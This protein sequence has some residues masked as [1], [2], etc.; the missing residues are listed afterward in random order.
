MIL[1]A[2]ETAARWGLYGDRLNGGDLVR[3]QDLRVR[4]Q[5]FDLVEV[6]AKRVEN[7]G[8]GREKRVGPAG[9]RHGN[10]PSDRQLAAPRVAPDR[11]PER[12]HRKLQTPAAAPDRHAGGK[13]G[14]S[15]IDL[16]RDAG[17]RVID[18]ERRAGEHHAVEVRKRDAKRQGLAIGDVE[19][20]AAD[21]RAVQLNRRGEQRKVGREAKPARSACQT[22]G[23][24]SAIKMFS[25]RPPVLISLCVAAVLQQ[26]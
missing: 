5:R 22:A 16:P 7:G 21:A 11:S 24:P 23:V 8:T 14:T 25:I 13:G 9:F 2:V 3:R 18:M 17:I 12:H 10:R 20:R 1:R 6:R 15:E 4:R 26:L 19:R